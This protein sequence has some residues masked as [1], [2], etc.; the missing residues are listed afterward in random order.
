MNAD[1][2][3]RS[4]DCL[5]NFLT[6]NTEF[7]I[8]TVSKVDLCIRESYSRFLGCK[9]N[10]DQFPYVSSWAEDLICISKPMFRVRLRLGCLKESLQLTHVGRDISMSKK[11]KRGAFSLGSFF[12][13]VGTE[14]DGI[15]RI[16]SR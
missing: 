8:Q 10:G 1:P 6:F 9:P 2:H 5:T 16:N 14:S 7:L 11:P 4:N 3:A 15:E 13:G 12:L